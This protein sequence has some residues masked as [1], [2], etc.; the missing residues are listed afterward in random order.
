MD[1]IRVVGEGSTDLPNDKRVSGGSMRVKSTSDE[2][3]TEQETLIH[4]NPAD[5]TSDNISTSIETMPD[6]SLFPTEKE[7]PLSPWGLAKGQNGNDK[8]PSLKVGDI[9]TAAPFESVKEAVSRFG[10][11]VDWKAHKVQTTEKRVYIEQQQHEKPNDEILLIKKKSE[12]EEEARL[13]KE[14]DSTKWLIE[15]L[16]LKLE[17]AQTEEHEAK[18]Y[19]ELVKLG[20]EE[21]DQGVADDSSVAAKAQLEVAVAELASAKDE[22]EYQRKDYDL[23]VSEKD[24]AVKRA[25]EAVSSLKDVE[26][27]VENLTIQL[28]MTKESLE[29]TRAAHLEAEGYRIE[30]DMT[31]E[32]DALIWNQ[33]LEQA[34]EELEKANQQIRSIENKKST[35]AT[36][37]ALLHGL[38]NELA[39][40]KE[41]K[42]TRDNPE[43][44]IQAA[45][46]NVE[47]VKQNITKA[48]EEIAYLKTAVSSL[49][50][51]LE[52]E[53]AALAA[54]RQSEGMAEVVVASL[55][56]EL[57]RTISEVA[58]VQSKEK[59][60]RKKMVE[61]PRQL[62][63]AAQ[64][65]DQAKSRAQE[66]REELKKAKETVEQAKDGASTMASRLLAAQKEIEAAKAIEKLALAAIDALHKP[67]NEPKTGV[68]LTM[69]EYYELS[70]KA[71]EAEEAAHTRVVEAISLIDLA[72]ETESKRL[73]KLEQVTLELAARKQAFDAALQKAE[74]AEQGKLG[75]EKD[76]RKWRAEHEQRRKAGLGVGPRE[77]FEE[78]KSFSVRAISPFNHNSM[79][80]LKTVLPERNSNSAELS[81]EVR[82]LKKK[83]R[84]FFP[85]WI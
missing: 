81:P 43:N 27:Q 36:A 35:L 56:A 39:A 73:S 57:N 25:R 67:E 84:S 52:R 30:A 65:T 23:L 55:E 64:E 44:R 71:H 60:A 24:L 41:S 28:M 76:L 40:Y 74:K 37:T 26:R 22:L 45:K 2:P 68:T 9:D 75:V 72:K 66:A 17:R 3:E 12:A 46:K 10:R 47:D 20:V 62:Q 16:N 78:V 8:S 48:T 5:H 6:D 59:E 63:K 31:R 15:E 77:G 42:L 58:L 85:I 33:E 70:N 69:E 38:K 29:S 19:V 21:T 50:N 4:A 82:S 61:L 34:Q 80:V 13:Q 49:K 54:V 51:E 14:L 18:Q 32:Q 79:P 11:V 53:K 7:V 83:K 1:D